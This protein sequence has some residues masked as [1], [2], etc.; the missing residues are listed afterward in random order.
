MWNVFYWMRGSKKRT[1][2]LA[3]PNKPLFTGSLKLLF[4]KTKS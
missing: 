2:C 1:K 3:L 4:A